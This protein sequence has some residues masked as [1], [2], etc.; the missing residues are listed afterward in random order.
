MSINFHIKTK[1]HDLTPQIT[2]DV[3]EKLGVIEK[4]LDTAGDKTVLAEIEIGLRSKRHQK[5]DIYRAEINL[6]SNGRMYRAVTRSSTITEALDDLKD[7][8]TKQLRRNKDK[9][10]SMFLKGARQIK[11][12][13]KRK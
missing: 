2:S 3:H 12:M 5:G 9:K 8:I 6:S 1:D 10:E 13:L 7:E 4:Y 11:K